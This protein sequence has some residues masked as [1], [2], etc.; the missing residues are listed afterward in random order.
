[1]CT[2]T[3]IDVYLYIYSVYHMHIFSIHAI[4]YHLLVADKQGNVLTFGNG[5][6]ANVIALSSIFYPLLPSLEGCT[7]L[8]SLLWDCVSFLAAGMYGQLGH[9]NTEKQSAPKLVTAL[10]DHTVYLLACGNFHT[11]SLHY[12]LGN[13]NFQGYTKHLSDRR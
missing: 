11:V 2:F 13:V 10:E 5:R 6:C 4:C 7:K 1:M 12:A 9:G 3:Y 8:S